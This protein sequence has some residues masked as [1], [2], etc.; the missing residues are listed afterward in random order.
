MKKSNPGTKSRTG[1]SRRSPAPL[2]APTEQLVELLGSPAPETFLE[3]VRLT[4]KARNHDYFLG[5]YPGDHPKV[6]ELQKLLGQ[7]ANLA[8][9]ERE[10]KQRPRVQADGVDRWELVGQWLDDAITAAP[11]ILEA[12]RPKYWDGAR[13][14]LQSARQLASTAKS[15]EE[16]RRFYEI[17]ET[18]LRKSV[19]AVEQEI[20]GQIA[21]GEGENWTPYFLVGG[22]ILLGAGLVGGAGFW[23]A[24]TYLEGAAT[25]HTTVAAGLSGGFLGGLAGLTVDERRRATYNL[26]RLG[27]DLTEIRRLN[28]RLGRIEVEA[29]SNRTVGRIIDL[30]ASDDLRRELEIYGN[31]PGM[32]DHIRKKFRFRLDEAAREAAGEGG[33]KTPRRRA[34]ALA[35]PPRPIDRR[36]EAAVQALDRADV[37]RFGDLVLDMCQS[38]NA[39]TH[40]SVNTS[41]RRARRLIDGFSALKLA[42]IR[43]EPPPFYG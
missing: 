24:S 36:V 27:H 38:R 39:I 9:L 14:G 22:A 40:A 20:A 37:N 31:D 7:A 17:A 15:I 1:S 16:Y 43:T 32:R 26:A 41:H 33:H 12:D 29:A 30:L 10:R 5:G 28:E 2:N 25:F 23:L 34:G 19:V 21:A 8:G 18:E 6:R 4:T 11:D 35:A 3:L 42:S 13:R